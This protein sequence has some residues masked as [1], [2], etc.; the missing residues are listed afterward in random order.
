MAIPSLRVL[1]LCTGNSARSQM[2]EAILRQMTHGT[3]DV[4]SAGTTPEPEIH[5]MAVKALGK[6]GISV[7]GQYPKP[8]QQ[9]LDQTFDYVI[10]VC[11]R[12]AERCLPGDP[13]RI[14]WSFEDPAA[15]NGSEDVRPRAFNSTASQMVNRIRIW[16][17]LPSVGGSVARE[18]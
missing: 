18:R 6:L 12:S 5:P 10:T 13:E 9:F 14:H 16:L 4:T 11:D 2:A 8:L 7:G 17:A 15:V 3:F 1:F